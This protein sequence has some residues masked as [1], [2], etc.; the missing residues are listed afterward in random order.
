MYNKALTQE[1]SDFAAENHNLV[2]AFL[3]IKGYPEDEYYDIAAFGFLSAVRSYFA[4]EDLRSYA[5]S[6]IAFNRMRSYVGRHIKAETTRTSRLVSYDD[7][8]SAVFSDTSPEQAYIK[9][10]CAEY[11][12][13]ALTPSQKL[14]L[15]LLTDGSGLHELSEQSGVTREEIAGEIIS[16]SSLVPT[17][18]EAIA[19]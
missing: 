6:T 5:F 19:A 14:A 3:N 12:E 17:L 4:R 11:I 15:H 10:E 7:Y 8:E 13:N 1:Q 9:K 18:Y 16:I 2:Y